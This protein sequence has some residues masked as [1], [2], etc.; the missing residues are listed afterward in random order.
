MPSLLKGFI[1]VAVLAVLAAGAHGQA[2]TFAT[3]AGPG[4]IT[5]IFHA[6]A[7]I[8]NGGKVIYIDPCK[9]TNF[10][11]MPK[12][13]LILVTHEHGDHVDQ[14]GSS[15]KGLSKDGTLVIATA[16]IAK[17]IPQATV[18]AN[19]ES[20]KCDKFT[21]EAVPSYNLVRG[22]GPGK[23]FHPQGQGN[24]YVISY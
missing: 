6:T 8:E 14:D 16:T 9:P 21:L 11:G 24:G 10:S 2:Q 18:M 4:K 5:P 20:R 22:P 13:D 19:G 12:A 3:S 1:A 7:R 15:I 17:F 23:L